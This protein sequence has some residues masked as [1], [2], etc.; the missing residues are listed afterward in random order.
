V[1]LTGFRPALHTAHRPNAMMRNVLFEERVVTPL[2]AMRNCL[3]SAAFAVF[4]HG[5]C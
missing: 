1:I 3:H 2:K 5:L 4:A